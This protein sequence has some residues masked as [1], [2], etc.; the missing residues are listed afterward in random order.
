MKERDLYNNYTMQTLLDDLGVIKRFQYSASKIHYSEM[1]KKQQ[2]IFAAFD[3]P[4][5]NTL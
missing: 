2:E 1:T 4:L 5:P 3:L